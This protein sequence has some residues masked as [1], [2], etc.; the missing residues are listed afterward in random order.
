MS[1]T[2]TASRADAD[3]APPADGGRSNQRRRTQR[4]LIEAALALRSEGQAHTLADVAQ[5]AL[6]SRATAYRY[7]NSLDALM[8]MAAF[9]GAAPDVSEL[10][11]AHPD[12]ADAAGAAALGVNRLFLDDEPALHAMIKGFMQVWLDAAEGQRPPRPGRRTQ[13]IDPIVARMQPPLQPALARRL[14]AALCM[15]IG[16]E[17][18]IALRDVAELD[19]NAAQRTAAWAAR[20]LVQA[21]R[22]EARGAKTGEALTAG[23][24]PGPNRLRAPRKA[25]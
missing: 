8:A 19:A 14:R 17:A 16:A 22:D 10:L 18:V 6:V 24:A 11:R 13:F 7:F 2:P 5:R 9:D 21:A 1:K 3:E 4:A 23:A 20:A 15:V 25:R 12:A